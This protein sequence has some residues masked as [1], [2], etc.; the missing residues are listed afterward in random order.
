GDPVPPFAVSIPS[1]G[2]APHLGADPARLPARTGHAPAGALRAF[3]AP[4]HTRPDTPSSELARVAGVT[5]RRLLD[6]PA[7]PEAA[8]RESFVHARFE[9]RAAGEPD[10]VA[11]RFEGRE[12][13]YGE[14]DRRA[15]AVAHRL[16]ELGVG[17]DTIV[18]VHVERSVELLVAT[19]GVLKAGAA[20]LP[21]DP[22][23]PA[24]RVAFMLSDARAP[25]VLVDSTRPGEID[26]EATTVVELAGIG[27]A[28][29]PP[30]RGNLRPDHLAYV[31]YTSGSTGRP[32]GV[33]VEHRNVA[34][35]FAGMDR[36]V[37]ETPAGRWLAVTSL[38][39]DISVL[40]LFWTLARGFEVVIHV[41]RERTAADSR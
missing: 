1:H 23:F 40:E 11:L 32:K 36:V 37:R 29:A 6:E 24:D 25:V 14:L 38:S 41:D 2:G 18:G 21:L 13:S 17:H 34:N 4:A 20:Y 12:V 31:I 5:R 10:R 26:A 7:G 28:D 33:L 30:A 27:T 35:F 15:N 19:L 16:R 3:L 9:E 8:P 39:F 22:D